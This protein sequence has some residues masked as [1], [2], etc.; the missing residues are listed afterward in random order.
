LKVLIIGQKRYVRKSPSVPW[1]NVSL[2]SPQLTLADF[3]ECS[4]RGR[5]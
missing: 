4:L 3:K 1:V 2:D 5:F